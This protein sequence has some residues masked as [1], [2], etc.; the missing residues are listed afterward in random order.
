MYSCGVGGSE[1]ALRE[2]LPPVR[3]HIDLR[4]LCPSSDIVASEA[5]VDPSFEL[6][7]E[8]ELIKYH[9]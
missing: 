7:I 4:I 3:C 9:N 2:V 6:S 8:T 5:R 1:S